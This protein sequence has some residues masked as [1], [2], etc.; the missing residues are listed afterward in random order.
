MDLSHLVAA[1]RPALIVFVG[2]GLIA[3]IQSFL[4]APLAF[5]RDEQVPGMPPR[6]D[7]AV[8]SFR[9]LRTYA[10][11]VENLPAMVC[12]L[13]V[14]ILAGVSPILVNGLALA[15]LGFRLLFWVLYYGGVGLPA[16]G[17]R[18]LSY[19]GG[20]LSNLALGGA[21]LWALI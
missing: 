4:C 14:A 8:S 9:V 19:I 11:T 2:L 10:N 13:T 7:H 6:G 5:I 21:A 20:M 15:H 1:Y 18:T 16:G 12:A 17:P 3:L